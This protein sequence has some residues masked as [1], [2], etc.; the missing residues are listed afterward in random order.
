MVFLVRCR[1]FRYVAPLAVREE[2]GVGWDVCYDRIYRGTWIWQRTAGCENLWG[3][4][5][6]GRGCEGI[7]EKGSPRYAGL[8][9]LYG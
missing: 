6:G 4:L 1:P 5:R 7:R 9:A 8:K 2:S 3:S